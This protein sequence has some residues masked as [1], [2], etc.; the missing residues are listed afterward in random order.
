MNKKEY[1]YDRKRGEHEKRQKQREI[2]D[3]WARKNE[4]NLIRQLEEQKRIM[5]L[6]YKVA[7]ERLEIPLLSAGDD[8]YHEPAYYFSAFHTAM[9]AR[10]SYS[11]PATDIAGP[12]VT[13]TQILHVTVNDSVYFIDGTRAPETS[14]PRGEQIILNLSDFSVDGHPMLFPVPDGT[15]TT[16]LPVQ[17]SEK[18][19]LTATDQHRIESNTIKQEQARQQFLEAYDDKMAK[20]HEW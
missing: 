18:E 11:D 17:E 19:T 20:V 9:G 13:D 14:L 8:A 15:H 1:A 7:K 6:R 10:V 4:E 12:A 5:N 16:P 2:E 3:R